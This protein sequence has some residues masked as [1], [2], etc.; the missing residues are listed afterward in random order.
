MGG[1]PLEVWNYLGVPLRQK[2]LTRGGEI[3][4]ENRR[5]RMSA[6][7]KLRDQYRTDVREMRTATRKVMKAPLPKMYVDAR[8]RKLAVQIAEQ[9]AAAGAG[10]T[11][12]A[13]PL[14]QKVRARI[15]VAA[16][17]LGVS[18]RSLLS[19]MESVLG[20]PADEVSPPSGPLAS[21]R[22]DLDKML[23]AEIL[24]DFNAVKRAY[25]ESKR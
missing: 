24:S 12:D 11:V 10:V 19:Y 22:D 5:E 4:E 6:V 15:D 7:E 16:T 1:V 25:K 17:E 20:N 13:L 23:G 8:K 14:E 18:R 21:F 2:N 9:E 3:V